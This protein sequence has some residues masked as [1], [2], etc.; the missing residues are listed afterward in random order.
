MAKAVI[1]QAVVLLFIAPFVS[2]LLETWPI[3]VAGEASTGWPSTF[4]HYE[5]NEALWSSYMNIL[6]KFV[7]AL[8]LQYVIA[9]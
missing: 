2:Y 9:R 5:K 7:P 4:A 1:M 3:M 8:M 6:H